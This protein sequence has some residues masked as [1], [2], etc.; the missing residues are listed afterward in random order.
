MAVAY[1]CLGSNL[2]EREKNL[3]RALTMLSG[4]VEIGRVSSVYETESVP[5]RPRGSEHPLFLNLVCRIETQL[6]PGDLLRLAKEIERTMGRGAGGE[7]DAPRVMDVDILLY[8]DEIVETDSLAIP[9][10]RLADRAF[11]LI[12]LAEIAPDLV[13]PGRR[14]TIAGLAD[15]VEGREGVWKYEGGSD[16][17]AICGR[18]L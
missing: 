17:S 10:P 14:M 7:R 13:H 12:P 15:A 4:S 11:V 16:V 3:C 9:H 8:D 18:A 1:L 2:G 5:R 6:S